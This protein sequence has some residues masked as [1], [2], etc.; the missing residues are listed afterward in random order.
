V[1]GIPQAEFEAIEKTITA[2]PTA[3]TFEFNVSTTNASSSTSGG[4][5]AMRWNQSGQEPDIISCSTGISFPPL[6]NYRMYLHALLNFGG[7]F[8][9][10]AVE[11]DHII[12]GDIE[13]RGQIVIGSSSYTH[14]VRLRPRN[15]GPQDPFGP[16][17]T[18]LRM[19]MDRLVC[20]V[21]TQT[22]FEVDLTDGGMSNTVIDIM[23]PLGGAKGF[24]VTGLAATTAFRDNE[25]RLH[26]VHAQVTASVQI[27]TST[28]NAANIFGN[29]IRAGCY[30][31]N[32]A[33]GMEV[34]GVDNKIIL[35]VDDGEGTPTIGLD[36]KTSAL[37][38]KIVA[39]NL[40]ATTPITG[41]IAGNYV[42][43]TAPYIAGKAYGGDAA[44][45]TPS[46]IAANQNDYN[47]TGLSAATVLR[48]SSDATRNLTGLQ[49]GF[50]GRVISL[51]NVGS[52]L[53]ILPANS[54]SS[55][56][57]YRFQ[58][59]GDDLYLFPGDAVHL[60]Y[61]TRSVAGWHLL[62]G[63]PKFVR[64]PQGGTGLK[65][66]AVGDLL[67]AD[68][69]SS[70]SRVAAVATGKAIVS[71][72]VTTLPAYEDIG[73]GLIA[74]LSQKAA[75]IPSADMFG[76]ADSAA[77]N[78]GKKASA[79]NILQAGPGIPGVAPNMYNTGLM[80]NASVTATLA[81]SANTLYAFPFYVGSRQTWTRIGID[82]TTG[83]AGNARL[84]IFSTGTDGLPGTLIADEGTV[85]TA[86][87]GVKEIT[88]SRPLEIGWYYLV[89]VSDATATIRAVSWGNN[90]SNHYSAVIGV[91]TPGTGDPQLSKAFA[92]AAL[93]GASPFGAPTRANANIPII[94]MRVV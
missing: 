8:V 76:L 73:V 24:V 89:I 23:E 78:A 82:V 10:P 7:S 12:S 15:E 57:A 52:F 33:T 59:Y 26:G 30:P 91:T 3:T 56:A 43:Y 29:T 83:V 71:K 1:G 54:G 65:T 34:Y 25:V 13:W 20:T 86:T 70:L 88:I 18:S 87:T 44:V 46:Q 62:G 14:C 16:V 36:L 74:P 21:N 58:F 11:F 49:G 4:G 94:T 68:T 28:V 9:G 42:D 81:L 72:G 51:V 27:G 5:A 47:P 75:L 45:I 31:G 2:V 61:D 63:Y 55:T 64:A 41:Q 77:S 39:L 19:V 32:G 48:L 35:S 53:M 93:S 50:D 69:A 85:S 40:D 84:G 6:Q 90:Q 92:Y 37:R 67:S 80:F 60:R 17:I 66:Y 22:A 79:E 38:N